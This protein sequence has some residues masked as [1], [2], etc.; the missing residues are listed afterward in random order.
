VKLHHS[1]GVTG[2]C[3]AMLFSQIFPNRVSFR[4]T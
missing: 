4:S 2:F 1:I 3:D